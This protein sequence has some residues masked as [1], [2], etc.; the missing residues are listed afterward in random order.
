MVERRTAQAKLAF[1]PARVV[2]FNDV[3]THAMAG[4]PCRQ[5]PGEETAHGAAAYTQFTRDVQALS[6]CEGAF[7]PFLSRLDWEV[8]C[9]AKTRGPGSNALDDLLRIDGVSFSV[10]GTVGI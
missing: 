8:A 6:R 9:W 2:K 7:A 4:C 1:R 10:C 5:L 3:V